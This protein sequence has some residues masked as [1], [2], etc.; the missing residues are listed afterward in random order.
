MCRADICI[1][2]KSQWLLEKHM[3][4]GVITK[5]VQQ[6]LTSKVIKLFNECWKAGKKKDLGAVKSSADCAFSRTDELQSQKMIRH[7]E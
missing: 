5:N 4:S 1:H 6:E 7:S 3:C 2:L